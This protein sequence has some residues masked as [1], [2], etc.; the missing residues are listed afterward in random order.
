MALEYIKIP[1]EIMMLEDV[2]D[3]QRILLGLVS[4][5]K[6]GL[7]MSNQKLG[8]L[9][10]VN[11]SRISDLLG[12]LERKNHVE[13]VNR[14]SRHRVVLLSTK[15]ESKH[16]STFENK[17]PTFDEK[18]TYFRPISEHNN[19]NKGNTPGSAGDSSPSATDGWTDTDTE[20]VRETIGLHYPTE[21][22][23]AEIFQGEAI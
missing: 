11:P 4:S 9:L 8:T 15:L 6:N 5:L 13:I 19:S 3:K 23:L 21:E 2:N 12:D 17:R 16:D 22:E 20:A 14:Q 1:V 7:K 18:R 10:H